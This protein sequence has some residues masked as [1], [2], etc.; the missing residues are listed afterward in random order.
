MADIYAD[1]SPQYFGGEGAN[2]VTRYTGDEDTDK[3]LNSLP[4]DKRADA[5]KRLT[6]PL[7]GEELAEKAKDPYYKMDRSQFSRYLGWKKNEDKGILDDIGLLSEGVAHIFEQ[8]AKTAGSVADH[9]L[10]SLAKLGP[11][12]VE[13][14]YQGT[15]NMYGM[16]AQSSNPTSKF[17]RFKAAI[18]GEDSDEGYRQYQEAREFNLDSIDL[19]EGKKTLL[20]NKDY[21]DHEMTQAMSYIADPSLFIPFAKIGGLGLRAIGMGEKAAML[22]ARAGAIQNRLIGGALKYGIGKPIELIGGATRGVID[23]GINAGSLAAETVTGMSA[24]EIATTVRMGSLGTSA[25]SLAG[26]S[27]PIVSDISN[28]YVAGG[29]AHGVGQALSAIGGQ[30]QR[31][32]RGFLSYAKAALEADKAILSPSA[33]NLLKVINAADPLL[34]LSADITKGAAYGAVIG[35]G[36]GYGNNGLEGMW[37]GAGAGIALGGVGGLAGG[38]LSRA[39]GAKTI[40]RADI[41]AKYAIE[42]AKET[43]KHHTAQAYELFRKIGE[44]TGTK[45]MMDGIVVAFDGLAPD[46][47]FQFR[48]DANHTKFLDD[49]GFDRKTGIHKTDPTKPKQLSQFEHINM[50]GVVMETAADGQVTMHINTTKLSKGAKKGFR[51]GT[52]PHEMLHL[53][54]RKAVMTPHFIENLKHDLLGVRDATGKLLEGG[55]INPDESKAFFREYMK[56]TYNKVDKSIDPTGHAAE[57]KRLSDLADRAVDEYEK[58][59]QATLTEATV[60]SKKPLLEHLTEEFGAYYFQELVGAKPPDFLF[61]AGKYE[62]LRGVMDRTVNRFID[63][64]ENKRSALDPRFSFK[65]GRSLSESFRDSSGKRI[66]VGSIDYMISDFLKMTQNQN[67]T[68][69]IDLTLMSD[70]AR[71]ELILRKGL[72]DLGRARGA[73]DPRKKTSLS[74]DLQLGKAVHAELLAIDPA[75]QTDGA[76]NLVGHLSDKDVAGLIRAGHISPAMGQKI[77]TLQALAMNPDKSVFESGYWG[78]THTVETGPNVPRITGD[79]VPFTNRLGVLLSVD[80]KVGKNGKVSMVAHTLD[81]RVNSERAKN[82]WSNPSVRDL[83]NGDVMLFEADYIKYITNMGKDVAGGKVESSILLDNGDGNGGKRRDVMH[84]VAGVP[85]GAGDVYVNHPIGE[86]YYDALNAYTMLSIGR[87]QDIRL[88]GEKVLGFDPKNAIPDIGRNFSPAEMTYRE[89]PNGKHWEHKTGYR[90]HQILDGEVVAYDRRGE[91]IGSYATPEQAMLAGKQKL[92]K[93]QQAMHEVAQDVKAAYD[94][95]VHFSPREEYGRQKATEELHARGF[96]GKFRAEYVEMLRSLTEEYNAKINNPQVDPRFLNGIRNKMELIPKI[97]EKIDSKADLFS[98]DSVTLI[99]HAGIPARLDG[100]FGSNSGGQAW[101]SMRIG[102]IDAHMK[103]WDK[104]YPMT[105]RSALNDRIQVMLRDTPNM[106]P[107]QL[108]KRLLQYGSRTGERL[109]AEAEAVGF[110]DWLESKIQPTY[111][112]TRRYDAATGGILPRGQEHSPIATP[113]GENMSVL[114]PKEITDFLKNNGLSLR[115]D[116]GAKELGGLQTE[117]YV[118]GG[119]KGEYTETPIRIEQSQYHHGVR[120]HYGPDVVVHTRTTVRFDSEGNKYLYIEEIQSNNSESILPQG[121][122]NKE[123][124]KI[125]T[126]QR[127]DLVKKLQ[128]LQELVNKYPDLK[129]RERV[130]EALKNGAFYDEGFGTSIPL[131]SY[132]SDN[133]RTGQG[134]NTTSKKVTAKEKEAR[135]IALEVAKFIER[136][137]DLIVNQYM[138]MF[139]ISNADIGL[140]RDPTGLR[141]HTPKDASHENVTRTHLLEILKQPDILK[142]I[143]DQ[144]VDHNIKYYQDG[145]SDF[146][147]AQ[148]AGLRLQMSDGKVFYAN[149]RFN[150]ASIGGPRTI[151]EF[152]SRIYTDTSSAIAETAWETADVKRSNPN[153]V[154][155]YA[156]QGRLHIFDTYDAYRAYHGSL[157]DPNNTLY[158]GHSRALWNVLD[159]VN[160]EFVEKDSLIYRTA[161]QQAEVYGEIK[162]RILEKRKNEGNTNKTVDL[163]ELEAA[164]PHTLSRNIEAIDR[165]FIKHEEAMKNKK[166]YP[167]EVINERTLVALKSLIVESIRKGINTLVLTHPDD[168]PTVSQMKYISRTGLYGKALPEIWGGFLAKYGIKIQ[169]YG[170]TERFLKGL[171]VAGNPEIKKLFETLS[172]ASDGSFDANKL[173]LDMYEQGKAGKLDAR[174]VEYISGSL[175]RAIHEVTTPRQGQEDFKQLVNTTTKALDKRVKNGEIPK[176]FYD[177]YVEAVNVKMAESKAFEELQNSIM[178]AQAQANGKQIMSRDE[179]IT[180]MGLARG[181]HIVLNDKIKADFMSGKAMTSYSVAETDSRGGRRYDPFG[182][183]FQRTFIGKYFNDNKDTL[184]KGMTVE[185]KNTHRSVG[186]PQYGFT[187]EVKQGFHKSGKPN[188]IANIHI[189]VDGNKAS[190]E[191]TGVAESMRGKKL[192]NVLLSEAAERLRSQGVKYLDGVIIDPENRPYH[193]RMRTIGNAESLGNGGYYDVTRSTLDRNAYYSPEEKE[194]KGRIQSSSSLTE[195]N[196]W[197][198]ELRGSVKSWHEVEMPQSVKD[199]ADNLDVFTS[200]SKDDMMIALEKASRSDSVSK[201][202]YSDV[203]EGRTSLTE[204]TKKL[205]K[206]GDYY[207]YNYELNNIRNTRKQLAKRVQEVMGNKRKVSDTDARRSN[208]GAERESRDTKYYSPS[209]YQGGDDYYKPKKNIFESKDEQGLLVR[210]VSVGNDEITGNPDARGSKTNPDNVGWEDIGHYPQT[211]KTKADNIWEAKNSGLWYWKDNEGVRMKNPMWELDRPDFTHSEW[212]DKF[213]YDDDRPNIY[214]RYEKPKYDEKGNLLEKGKLSISSD[215]KQPISDMSDANFY[216]DTVASSL[217]VPADHIDAYLFGASQKVKAQRGYGIKDQLPIHFSVNENDKGGQTYN[218]KSLKWKKGFIGRYAAENPEMSKEL[219]LTFETEKASASRGMAVMAGRVAGKSTHNHYLQITEAGKEVGHITWKTQ[220]GAKD[221]RKIFSDPS[222][223]VEP[224]YRGKNYQH[225]LYSEAAERARA[226]GATDFFQRIEND[227]GLPLKSQVRTFGENYS[228]L[229]DQYTGQYMPATMDNFNKLKYPE[230]EIHNTEAD[231]TVNIEKHKGHELWVYAWSKIQSDKWYSL[232]ERDMLVLRKSE[233][234]PW[235]KKAMASAGGFVRY[236]TAED[237]NDLRGLRAI[238]HAPDTLTGTDI[239][240]AEG[241]VVAEGAGGL[242]YPMLQAER[243]SNAAWASQGE[244]FVN[245]TN[246]AVQANKD[247][248]KGVTAIMPL[249]FTS[250]EKARASVQGSEFYY[251]VFDIFKRGKIVSEKDLRIAMA[252]A[253]EKVTTHKDKKT[254]EVVIENKQTDALRKIVKDNKMNYDELIAS[255]MLTLEDSSIQ[256]FGTRAPMIDDFMGAVWD[257]VMKGLSDK[258]KQEVMRFFPEWDGSK[259]AG[260]FTLANLKS[261]MGNTLTDSLT[262]GLKSGDVYGIIKFNDFVESMD[263]GHRSYNTGIVQKN[264]QKPEILLLKRPINVLDLHETSISANS[265]ERKLSDLPSNVQTNLLG[266]NSNPYGATRTKDVGQV[267]YRDMNANYSVKEN[268][269]EKVAPNGKVLQAINGYIIMIQGDKFKVYNSQKVQVGIYASE[270]EAKKRA[271]RN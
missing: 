36:L 127:T 13:A 139:A 256:N 81:L 258:K 5:L 232:N 239:T 202:I 215:Y 34:S 167:L 68:G 146:N 219:K 35:G 41:M 250:Y 63:H 189:N 44:M 22:A 54:L 66:R 93:Q 152:I 201:Q 117:N 98:E 269:A 253:V 205:Q 147:N 268:F 174:N 157:I 143:A 267:D 83:W 29:V 229:L 138:Q 134:R 216:K 142:N 85:L 72:D 53:I 102:G 231:G 225:L 172:N 131:I 237:L 97:L 156:S 265:G 27:V 111:R 222:V 76:G 38:L 91:R 56:R 150:P 125:L 67:R 182:H 243:G 65:Q 177:A 254:G 64:F 141:P 180:A 123:S 99:Q 31:G 140:R 58:T 169:K 264:G 197:L 86:I 184:P 16:L 90:F 245:L 217:G 7:T 2:S 18:T 12:G 191:S 266:M 120:G 158:G 24:K 228:K 6:A 9:P 185:F 57:A 221:G 32:P 163:V 206:Q 226:M 234:M 249:T 270:Q 59:G 52:V 166:A 247:A 213:K 170:S 132:L 145:Y 45:P 1:T 103:G 62:G 242:P 260:A 114:D 160:K 110:V 151:A 71:G 33:Q 28:A 214:G 122:L 94:R 244:G 14:F 74:N 79:E 193:A 236:A 168:A 70:K 199:I 207:T 188:F 155:N 218:Q 235:F 25:A 190:V 181:N 261:T 176:E 82:M 87:M 3:Y 47:R 51:A 136:N 50:E 43:G 11:S 109:W 77:K 107:Q 95:G 183:A 135:K 194:L 19:A 129:E 42:G 257:R 159:A 101:M 40:E 60:N 112:L 84:Q 133:Q 30:I 223:S 165:E 153:P 137:P 154:P 49:N 23:Y 246:N 173:V 75:R 55:S 263:S 149:Q 240:T 113:K 69:R 15:R 17:F 241:R 8:I 230:M 200:A 209:D 233:D 271:L 195:L 130:L 204:A 208:T 179:I 48:N 251:N 196:S 227:L 164:S 220:I 175:S 100:S 115:I 178:D 116:T 198:S 224:A 124:Q 37:Q 106:T 46:S 88:T 212:F 121:A 108:R 89:A 248:G 186:D 238:S 21:I 4:E 78:A 192:N 80:I 73:R 92:Q 187:L 10:Q 210:R 259:T 252:E 171:D 148:D 39:T 162:K 118:F 126:E 96:A 211:G 105:F 128:G 119:T 161:K 203:V 26:H 144:F 20:V 104:I 262:K 255:V 61:F